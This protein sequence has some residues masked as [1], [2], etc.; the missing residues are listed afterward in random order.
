MDA[1]EIVEGATPSL[2]NQESKSLKEPKPIPTRYQETIL[3]APSIR[4]LL[5]KF[6]WLNKSVSEDDSPD[7]FD[8]A[9]EDSSAPPDVSQMINFRVGG[10]VRN[11][12][13]HSSL[14]ACH[15]RIVIEGSSLR[16]RHWGFVIGGES[17]RVR[18]YY[19]LKD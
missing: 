15:R 3:L 18:E 11:Q 17:S 10:V 14:T 16:R 1:V 6:G 7:E 4:F 13:Y 5:D 2:S 12:W 8:D 19:K 9:V